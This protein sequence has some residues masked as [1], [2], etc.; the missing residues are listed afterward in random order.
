MNKLANELRDAAEFALDQAGC[1]CC[2][3]DDW[4]LAVSKLTEAIKAFDAAPPLALTETM[5]ACLLAAIEWRETPY[6]NKEF[7]NG[8]LCD[9]IRA[10]TPEDIAALNA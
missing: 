2:G 10:L 9:A 1:G 4:P 8:D 5:R 3:G 6:Y 7:A